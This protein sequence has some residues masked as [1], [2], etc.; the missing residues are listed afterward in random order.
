M[1]TGGQAGSD[2]FAHEPTHLL[3]LARVGDGCEI[4]VGG[5]PSQIEGGEQHTA[6]E[7]QVLRMRGDGEAWSHQH[8]ER[9]AQRIDHTG[10]GLG[11]AEKIRRPT[12]LTQ[13]AAKRLIR[14]V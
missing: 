11:D 7:D 4:D 9:P 10:K 6:R 1:F 13:P 14:Q 3:D 8:L 12:S 2:H 5:R